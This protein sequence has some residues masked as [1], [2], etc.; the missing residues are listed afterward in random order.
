MTTPRFIVAA[1][2][3]LASL[4]LAAEDYNAYV[5]EAVRQMPH[6]GSYAQDKAASSALTEAIQNKDGRLL[7]APKADAPSYC[8]G[9]TYLVFL[10][11]LQNLQDRGQLSL[12]AA[13]VKALGTRPDG[14]WLLDGHGIWGRWNANGP[15][16][17]GV[18]RD[19]EIG[20]NFVD[21]TFAEAKAGDFMKIFW[22]E[23]VGKKESGHSVIFT[24]VKPVGATG[25]KVVEVCYWSSNK[26]EGFSEK[27]VPRERIKNAIFS[28]LTKPEHVVKFA[29]GAVS[30]VDPY[31]ASLLRKESSFSE[32]MEKTNAVR[33]RG[34]NGALQQKAH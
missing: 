34:P 6:G 8:S 19:L 22:K 7:V 5:L 24:G 29:L 23:D 33:T 21:D 10:K 32:A 4:A 11:T 27:C 28:R 31:L 2:F 9:A 15:G 16:T 13:T 18:F 3:A 1:T 26:P 14:D 17:A 12:D 25:S 20:H 30:P